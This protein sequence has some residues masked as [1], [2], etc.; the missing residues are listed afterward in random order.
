VGFLKGKLFM[1]QVAAFHKE[2]TMD[3]LVSFS[4]LLSFH[5]DAVPAAPFHQLFYILGIS[6]LASCLLS[7][8]ATYFSQS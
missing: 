6:L 5:P 2:V 1:S 7:G 3:D 8:H 4:W